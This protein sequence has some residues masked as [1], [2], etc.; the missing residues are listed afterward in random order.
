MQSIHFK[1]KIIMKEIF[2]VGYI[3]LKGSSHFPQPQSTTIINLINKYSV[4][5]LNKL[6]SQICVVLSTT[7]LL[8]QQFNQLR[9][10]PQFIFHP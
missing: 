2:V 5:I 9:S 4:K 6:P 7:I 3:N 8:L 10:R 1:Y